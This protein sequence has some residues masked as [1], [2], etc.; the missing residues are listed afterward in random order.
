MYFI[1]VYTK[2]AMKSRKGLEAY[3][4]FQS[5]WVDQV[6]TYNRDKCAI[7][8]LTA[9]V[10]HSQRLNE[11]CLRPWIAATKD[12]TVLCAHCNCMAGVSRVFML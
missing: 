10:M 6:L 9:K 1:G 4:Q 2:E 8:L 12:G 11:D 5:G 3:N 7:I